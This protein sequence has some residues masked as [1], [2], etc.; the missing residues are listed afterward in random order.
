MDDKPIDTWLRRFDRYF[1][2][3]CVMM[4]AG[5]VILVVVL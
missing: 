5:A 2:Y 1:V 4:A 3:A